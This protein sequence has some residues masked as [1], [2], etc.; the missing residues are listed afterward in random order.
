MR[1]SSGLALGFLLTLWLTATAQAAARPE[2]MTETVWRVADDGFGGFS[3]IHVSAEG[4]RFIAVSDKGRIAEGDIQRQDGEITSIGP[5]RLDWL[6][7]PRGQPLEDVL[8]DAEGIAI[9]ADGRIYV[10]FEYQHRV[11]R[12][13]GLGD[14]AMAL[15]GPPAFAELQLNSGLEGL[16]I[17]RRQRVYT[18]P[19][20]SGKL[21]RPFP[22][23]RYAFGRW[24][25]P[26]DIPRRD[27]Y[28]PV[29]LDFGPDDRLYLLERELRGVFFTSR[30]RRFTLEGD[31]IAQEEILLTT[32]PGRHQNLEGLSVWRDPEGALRLTMISD[33]GFKPFW[34]TSIVEYR[35][36]E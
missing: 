31:S 9:D 33:D 19:E 6:R 5:V 28:L 15:R 7:D 18:L 26:F 10:S 21:D 13:G 8:T 24:E 22:V 32:P 4:T 30:L 14:K 11:W 34:S 27:G 36:R 16:A 20:R 3:A 29:A 25:Q 35:L 17:D 12:Y 1:A 23:Y 2:L